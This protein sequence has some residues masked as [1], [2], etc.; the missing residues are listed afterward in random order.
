MSQTARERVAM[1]KRGVHPGSGMILCDATEIE[2]AI[3]AAEAAVEHRL[4]DQTAKVV[5]G[6]IQGLEREKE[7]AAA[8]A[9]LE[10][11]VAALREVLEYAASRPLSCSPEVHDT[12]VAVYKIVLADTTAAATAFHE[13]VRREALLEGAKA[14]D[15]EP[16]N[17]SGN[18]T[19]GFGWTDGTAACANRL[20]RLAGESTPEKRGYDPAWGD[21]LA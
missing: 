8:R 19:Y 15:I 4:H 13:R 1:L 7:L 6:A 12:G 5:H 9:D 18:E 17:D 11:Q 20:I 2:Q 16:D 3:L 10:G 14:C 21:I